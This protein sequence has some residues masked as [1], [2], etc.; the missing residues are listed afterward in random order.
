MRSG[1]HLVLA[2]ATGGAGGGGGALVPTSPRTDLSPMATAAKHRLMAGLYGVGP[3]DDDET[4]AEVTAGRAT[5]HFLHYEANGSVHL[6]SMQYDCVEVEDP[7]PPARI[8]A[9]QRDARLARGSRRAHWGDGAARLPPRGHCH[10]GAA[11]HRQAA[12]QR[13]TGW[14]RGRAPKAT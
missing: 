4:A 10:P 14:V 2:G 5:N 7:G 9:N 6:L 12:L 3:G 8:Q 13:A 1:A 11:R